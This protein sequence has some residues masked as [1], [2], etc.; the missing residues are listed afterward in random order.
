MLDK[1][2]NGIRTPSVDCRGVPFW[3][4][5]SKLEIPE[6]RRQIRILKEMGMGGFFMHSRVGLNT[7]YLKKEW[8]ECVRACIDEAEKQGMNVWL[9]DEDRWPSGAA[10]GLV[11]KNV[12]FRT[13]DLRITDEVPENTALLAVF[14][15][16]L[17][18][19]KLV[20]SRRLKSADDPLEAGESRA[21]FSCKIAETMAW[22]NDQTYLDTMNPEAVREFLRVTHE[23]YASEIG[24]K[25]GTTV[26]GIFTDEP[27]YLQAK[28]SENNNT[29]K[30]KSGRIDRPFNYSLLPWTDAVPERFRAEFGYDLLDHM[31]E[32]F[33]QVAGEDFSSVRYHFFKL[34]TELF[35]DAFSRQIG[36]WCGEHKLLFTGHVLCED[37]ML[38]QRLRV[39]AAMRFYEYMQSPG[40]DLLTEHRALYDTVKQCASVAHQFGRKWRLCESYGCTGWDF[41]LFGHKALGEWLGALGINLRCHHLVWYS[42]AGEAKRDY[43]ASIFAQSPW[44]KK[45]SAV[46]DRFS[47]LGAALAD[48]EEVRDLLVVHP[49]ESVW[50]WKYE[51]DITDAER[52]AED[53]KL[54]KL[55]NERLMLNLDFDY[56]DEDLMARHAAV[57][58]GRL[59][60]KLAEYK[61][62][63]IPELR[64]IRDTTL[65]LLKKFAQAGG[66]VFYLGSAPERV[67]GVR[68]TAAGE[69]FKHFA[70]IAERDFD[71]VLSPLVRNV[72]LRD[73]KGR[74][75]ASTLSMLRKSADYQTLF[76]CNTGH[77]LGDTP[78][79]EEPM[80]RDRKDA[81]PE[82]EVTLKSGF[83]KIVEA[84]LDNG[85]FYPVGSVCENGIVTFKTSLGELGSRL[86]IACDKEIELSERP[87]EPRGE[88]LTSL[89]DKAWRIR[90]DEPNV[91]VLDHGRYR[92]GDEAWSE[93]KFFIHIDA[94][95]RERLGKEPRG[96]AMVQPY[97]FADRRPEKTLP[98]DVE[99]TFDCREV[100][101]KDLE[102]VLENPAVYTATVNGEPLP[103]E[104]TGYWVDPALRRLKLPARLLKAG[105]NTL[106][107]HCDYHELLPG[108]ESLFLL[109]EFGVENDALTTLPEALALGDWCAQGLPHYSGNLTYVTKLKGGAGAERLFLELGDWRGT[110]VGVR[111]NGGAEH[112]LAWP[113]FRAEIGGELKPDGDN[114]LAITVYG[115]R[116]N[117]FGPFYLDETWPC[118]SGPLQLKQYMHS[119][120]NLVPCGLLTAPKL[121]K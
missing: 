83:G 28:F 106:V 63:L 21:V 81:F 16:R 33:F 45:Y 7:P 84:D 62:V 44:Y 24:D 91:L 66:A 15:I 57:E 82:V 74:E 49:I 13:R 115:H 53:D 1:V 98:V 14:A 38:L 55:R 65:E 20:S 47:R 75:I 10:G 25:F 97:I 50:G 76:I 119:Y 85:K 80:V 9:Y 4:W 92:V 48:G 43:P 102:L 69:A 111:V 110:A 109:G 61:A 59:K 58:A 26:K 32:L 95:L 101:D 121:V 6:L 73:G 54:I 56:G 64:T 34:V 22:Y 60:I 36:E 31:P 99:Y 23:R 104:D 89:P 77:R 11:T 37:T 3:A 71:R 120:R 30:F 51:P 52:V 39:G 108:L 29:L 100:P 112:F 68:S 116:R 96:G 113:P 103:L 19:N 12:K 86:F 94:E 18:E 46:E 72:S 2:I 40:I 107:I 17:K 87:A 35:V 105:E 79:M 88:T 42:M 5:N 93:R 41:P 118:W 8:F 114:E 70:P 67:D 90:R 27:N 78:Q 117:A